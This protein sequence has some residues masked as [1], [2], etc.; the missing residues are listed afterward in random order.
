[1][2]AESAVRQDVP[3]AQ[4]TVEYLPLSRILESS[5]NPRRTVKD[6]HFA[7]LVG[8]IRTHGVLQPILVRPVTI[9]KPTPTPGP[10]YELVAGHRRLAAAREAFYPNIPAFIRELSDQAALEIQV[11]ENLQRSDLH[12]LE[13]A[14][15]YQR[16]LAMKYDIARIAER[17]GRSVK[18]VYDRVKLLQLIPA[19]QKVFLEDKIS[20]G[21]AIILARL[22]PKDQE[23]AIELEGQYGE[24]GD[25]GGALFIEER[26]LFDPLEDE[27][28]KQRKE[29]PLAGYKT[30]S[31][32][33]LQAWVDEHVRFDHAAADV[34][35]LFPET[36]QAVEEAQETKEKIVLVTHEHHVPQ[37][38]REGPPVRG[39][40]SWKSAEKKPCEHA[41]TGVIVIGPGRGD[42]LKVC[43]AKDKCK[44]HWSEWQ[45]ERAARAKEAGSK[46][47]PSSQD[48]YAAE[49]RRYQERQKREEA[50]ELR[51]KKALPT[52]L[53][54]IA[55]KITKASATGT[56]PL[57]DIIIGEIDVRVE[58][59]LIRRGKTSEDLVRHMA[60][61]TIAGRAGV[62]QWDWE[63]LAKRA[64]SLGVDVKKIVDQEAPVQTSAKADAPAKPAKKRAR[65]KAKR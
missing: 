3:S 44:V 10:H 36:H 56:G 21:H 46:S 28:A 32:R 33:E 47:G 27:R 34:P 61:L 11:I 37:E 54:A 45:R 14:Q 4:G 59:A 23:R 29:D 20:A 39:P 52:V 17:I 30:R 55:D 2:R 15:G 7:D 43:V 53:Q 48:R 38:A 12:A 64:R 40:R 24:Y 63:R 62:H 13:E 9:N 6:A 8:S 19:V 25:R 60:Y 1:V 41:V 50:E 51:R 35:D 16:L 57:A 58:S 26:T 31:V 22:K 18:Y 5:T 42:A 65:K 49:E